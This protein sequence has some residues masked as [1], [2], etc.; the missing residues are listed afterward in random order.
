ML[1][2]SFF[3][4]FTLRVPFFFSFFGQVREL[5]P[6]PADEEKIPTAGVKWLNPNRTEEE[7]QEEVEVVA[8]H[9]D[10]EDEYA[11]DFEDEEHGDDVQDQRPPRRERRP[12]LPTIVEAEGE[13]EEVRTEKEE[14]AQE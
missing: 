3:S 14:G 2:Q 1:S 9:G 13:A 11:E 5:V 7:E 8:T 10:A 4:L 6:E 12:S